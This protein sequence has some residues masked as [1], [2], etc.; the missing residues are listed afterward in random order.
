MLKKLTYEEL[1][2]KVKYLE[3]KATL[4]DKLKSE[5]ISS[6]NFLQILLNTNIKNPLIINQILL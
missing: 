5:I 1:E 3:S 6:K 2:G 4:V